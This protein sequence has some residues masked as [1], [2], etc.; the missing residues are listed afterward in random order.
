MV[1]EIRCTVIKNAKSKN[2]PTSIIER[3]RCLNPTDE[4]GRQKSIKTS[5]RQWQLRAN[6]S[7]VPM[8]ASC[9][10]KI[11]RRIMTTGRAGSMHCPL[12]HKTKVCQPQ[13]WPPL[14]GLLICLL[15][16]A[17]PYTGL[18]ILL[19]SFGRKIYLPAIVFVCILPLL[20]YFCL[21]FLLNILFT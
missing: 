1:E 8:T 2:R 14:K 17:Y 15:L 11:L 3:G 18:H 4:R 9:Q 19:M 12:G 6:D 13:H 10:W 5:S 7:F 16:P 21:L 20:F